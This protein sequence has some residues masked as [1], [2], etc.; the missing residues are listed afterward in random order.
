MPMLPETEL[1]KID[2]AGCQ[3]LTGAPESLAYMLGEQEYHVHNTNLCYGKAAGDNFLQDSLVPFVAV[4][5]AIG[6]FGAETLCHDGT[7]V[8]GGSV[9]QQM[10]FGRIQVSAAQA[11]AGETYILQFLHGTGLV[12]DAAVATS[13]YYTVPGAGLSKATGTVIPC[14]RMHCNHKIWA[15][16]KCTQ[17]GQTISFMF[18]IHVYPG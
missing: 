7:V 4:A 5:G 2:L 12:G 10:D 14:P 16:T 8:A 15:K 6:V 11:N 18:D 17:A 9:T 13:M 1:K 3:G